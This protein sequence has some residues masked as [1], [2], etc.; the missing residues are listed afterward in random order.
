MANA[1]G[2]EPDQQPARGASITLKTAA[3]D[4]T[5]I[6]LPAPA[7]LD[8]LREAILKALNIPKNRQSLL[9]NNVP[10]VDNQQ[11]EALAQGDGNLTIVVLAKIPSYAKCGRHEAYDEDYF[12]RTCKKFFCARCAVAHARIPGHLD[13]V[14]ATDETEFFKCFQSDMDKEEKKVLPKAPL[15]VPKLGA[16]PKRCRKRTRDYDDDSGA[17][18][19]TVF[20]SVVPAEVLGLVLGYFTWTARSRLRLLSKRWYDGVTC[21]V[22]D[23][24]TLQL[25][26]GVWTVCR[27][28]SAEHRV[29]NRLICFHLP[30]M[31][32]VIV[33]GLSINLRQWRDETAST[34][35]HFVHGLCHRSR[36]E[37]GGKK[38]GAK[39]S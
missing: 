31:S 18:S 32:S 28:Y 37:V 21:L 24:I 29:M 23:Y 3:G 6:P 25:Q 26:E 30:K 2:A 13:L 19:R 22:E 36:V 27:E 7:N 17:A 33:D 5:V 16:A 35:D 34:L 15:A 8:A 14:D 39:V 1:A 38:M 20:L 12:C 11:L 9:V 10:L 4:S